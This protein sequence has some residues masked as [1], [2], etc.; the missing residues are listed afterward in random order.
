MKKT[1]WGF[2]TYELTETVDWLALDEVES[3]QIAEQVLKAYNYNLCSYLNVL[4]L[5]HQYL[6]R[7]AQS[8]NGHW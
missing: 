6:A 7:G 4:K 8:V 1:D 3:Q 2:P 5:V